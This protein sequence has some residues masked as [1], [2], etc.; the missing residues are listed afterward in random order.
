[1]PQNL[2][3]DLS[4]VVPVKFTVG[5]SQ[6]F[7][8]YSE[9]INFIVN[10]PWNRSVNNLGS[11]HMTNENMLW[12]WVTF[13]IHK[14]LAENQIWKKPISCYDIDRT[15]AVQLTMMLFSH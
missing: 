6:N 10:C 13:N 1:M 5:V 7:V 9:Y 11:V 8:A 2:T 14:N 15:F 3:L 12:N 4:N